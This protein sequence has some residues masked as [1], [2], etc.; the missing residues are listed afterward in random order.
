MP[1]NVPLTGITLRLAKIRPCSTSYFEQLRAFP[2]RNAKHNANERSKNR[3]MFR[4]VCAGL[5]PCAGICNQR[6]TANLVTAG[7][8]RRARAM[9]NGV[10][11][12]RNMC[13]KVRTCVVWT[14]SATSLQMDTRNAPE[15][16]QDYCGNND[17]CFELILQRNPGK[18]E[19]P[20]NQYFS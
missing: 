19:I 6:K 5:L 17:A 16:R 3:A 13:R 4:A 12:G 15:E 2:Q 7:R 1:A 9:R 18:I 14:S 11:C 20:E 10:R 8:N